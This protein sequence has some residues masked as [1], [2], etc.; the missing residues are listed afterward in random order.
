MKDLRDLIDVD[1]LEP[2]EADRLR[3]V[4]DLLLLAGPP[5]EL[6]PALEH[7]GA[8]PSAQVVP[9]PVHRRRWVALGIAAAAAACL[10][11]GGGYLVGHPKSS[12]SAE[13][14]VSMHPVAG[15]GNALAVLKVAKPDSVGNWP[16]ELV[17]HGL[18]E[19]KQR[20]AYYELW[21]TRDGK[22]VLACGSFRVN[23]ETT[24]VRLSVPYSFKGIDGWVVTAHRPGQSEPGRVILTT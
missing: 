23:G 22:P 4:H 24:T 20:D 14:I 12:F 8:P 10:V 5:A 21:I 11:F 1:G 3:R 7:P 17:A 18:P 9:F 15:G 6:P 2:G 16:M 13:R 19:Q